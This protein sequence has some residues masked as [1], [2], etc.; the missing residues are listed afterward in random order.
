MA[1]QMKDSGVEWIGEIPDEW[2]INRVKYVCTEVLDQLPATTAPDYEFDYVDIS[3]V[4]YDNGIINKEAMSFSSAPSRA[5]RIVRLGDIIFST[6]RTYLKAIALIGEQDGNVI[7]STGFAVYRSISTDRR[8]LFY[9]MQNHS[10]VSTIEA[11][12]TGVSYPAIASSKISSFHI[13]LPSR[14]KQRRIADYL[15]AKCAEID[16]VVEKT[17][18]TI[19]EYRKLKQSI[20]TETVTKG[21]NPDAEMK[22]SGIPW[23][24]KIPD[25][26]RN[27]SIRHLLVARDGGA[28]GEEVKDE[29]EGIVCLRVADFD[30]SKGRFVDLD[31]RELTHRKYTNTQVKR[32]M[33]YPGDICVEKSGGG[34]KTPVGRAVLFDKNY[35]ALFANF[36]ERL[37]FNIAIVLSEFAEYWFRMWYSCR[38]SPYYINQTTG[39]QNIDLTLML[40]K[41]KMF[42]PNI[43]EQRRIADY[44]DAKCAELDTIIEKKEQLIEE[45]GSYKKSLIYE[46]VTGKKEVQA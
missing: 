35:T 11:H 9:A 17:R 1:R 37:R 26:W 15:D 4:T 14:T 31:E 8:F 45:L 20:I 5:R 24:G 29:D 36:M 27:N 30:Y 16:K 46:Y 40:A 10:F 19:E 39:I 42:F 6:V 23:I 32:L 13:V 33:L 21:L 44:L 41:E 3:S 22:D 18:E 7:V 2:S 28:W 43:D 34:E 12:S 38:C 25:S